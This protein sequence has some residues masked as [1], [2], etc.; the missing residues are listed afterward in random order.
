MQE[1]VGDEL[2]EV[3]ILRHKEVQT[4]PA[5]QENASLL[6]YPR[7]EENQRVDNEQVLCDSRYV[8]VHIVSSVSFLSSLFFLKSAAKLRKISVF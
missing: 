3:E 5:V 1:L 2:I 8:V 4:T 7:G 6:Q